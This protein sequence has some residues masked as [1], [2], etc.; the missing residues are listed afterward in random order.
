MGYDSYFGYAPQVALFSS[1]QLSCSVSEESCG[2]SRQNS[3]Y[4]ADAV[5]ALRSSAQQWSAVAN[6]FSPV[7]TLNGDNP[8]LIDASQASGSSLNMG[9]TAYDAEDGNISNAILFSQTEDAEDPMVDYLQVYTVVD[10]DN[11][12]TSV[13]RKVSLVLDTDSDGIFNRFDNDD[14]ND[15]V[16]D[17]SDQYPLDS[18][19]S[20][21]SDGDGM[22]DAWNTGLNINDPSDAG[23][24]LDIDVT[25]AEEFAAGT[26]PVG[27]LDIDGNGQF[28]GYTDG[29]LILRHMFGFSGEQLIDGSIAPDALYSSASQIESRIE[30]LGD[31]VDID[32]DSQLDALTD[33]LL[34]L[35]H[36]M[37]FNGS[38]LV[39]DAVSSSNKA[40]AS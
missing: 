31:R 20:A 6:G 5:S 3:I 12:S 4:G 13:T 24:D 25:A 17:S 29:L 10:S 34:I 1:P 39:D 7:L 36:L 33:G 38:A 22:A 30:A 18:R 37:D 27:T 28:E 26:V 14:D 23:S 9:A 2:V 8:L 19:Y 32:G 15:G 35:R 11:N 21:D 16:V 40:A